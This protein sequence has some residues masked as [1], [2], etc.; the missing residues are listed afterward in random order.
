MLSGDKDRVWGPG[1]L[2]GHRQYS[3]LPGAQNLPGPCPSDTVLEKKAG[4][5][6][7]PATSLTHEGPMQAGP[8]SPVTSPEGRN[9]GWSMGGGPLWESRADTVLHTQQ[10]SEDWRHVVFIRILLQSHI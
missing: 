1:G 8:E 2:H 9:V 5:L 4:S 10:R 3:Y 7:S 6:D